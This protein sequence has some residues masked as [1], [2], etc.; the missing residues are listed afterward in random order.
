MPIDGETHLAVLD[1]ES[2]SQAISALKFDL[3]SRHEA[4][5]LFGA[6]HNKG[7]ESILLNIEQTF[8]GKP[9]YPSPQNVQLI[10]YTL[11]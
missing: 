7:L 3:A 9:I 2:A 1:Y 6:D 11:S 10:C 5:P 8:D 4:S